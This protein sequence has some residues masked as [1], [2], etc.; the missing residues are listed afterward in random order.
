MLLD[1][2]PESDEEYLAASAKGDRRKSSVWALMD[3]MNEMDLGAL[4]APPKPKTSASPNKNRS[5]VY[6][7]EEE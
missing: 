7:I 3:E 5:K 1:T 6:S 2:T 4:H